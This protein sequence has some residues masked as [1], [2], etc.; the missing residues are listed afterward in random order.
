MRASKVLKFIGTLSIF[1]FLLTF[2]INAT[3]EEN[4]QLIIDGKKISGDV[5]PLLQEGRVLVPI[6]IVSETLGAQVNYNSTNKEVSITR[7]NEKIILTINKQ[8]AF[9][10]DLL[11]TLDV[12]A[13]IV[14]SRT[15]VPLRFISEALGSKVEWLNEEKTV[16][17]TNYPKFKGV[18]IASFDE[19]NNI[20][21]YKIITT[22]SV[23]Y[24]SLLLTNPNR[25]VLELEDILVE[26]ENIQLDSSGVGEELITAVRWSQF[27][28]KPLITRIVFEGNSANNYEVKIDEFGQMLVSFKFVPMAT[29]EKIVVIDPGHGGQDPGAVSNDGVK[30]KDVVL[31][32]GLELAK[33]LQKEGYKVVMTRDA[34]YYITLSDRAQLANN[35]QADAF[36]SIHVNAAVNSTA[37]GIETFYHYTPQDWRSS[38]LAP[39][40]QQALMESLK[41]QNRGVKQADFHVVRETTMPSVLVELGFISNNEDKSMMINPSFPLQTAEALLKGITTFFEM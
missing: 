26:T 23:K 35:L 15:M 17:V 30:E 18:E 34:D 1:T 10:N 20:I 6:R 3:A 31:S 5:P 24:S 40:L 19:E 7:N 29:K 9:K 21:T 4:I 33:L 2:G 14:D 27:Q 37:K 12:P 25:L 38:I 16:L 11:V 39:N 28:E 32:V 13:T 36:I 8:E 41:S 22:K